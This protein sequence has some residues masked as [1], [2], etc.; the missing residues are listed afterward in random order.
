MILFV[1][2][3][4]LYYFYRCTL[5]D[6]VKVIVAGKQ[7]KWNSSRAVSLKWP[8]RMRTGVRRSFSF[9]LGRKS[10]ITV[11]WMAGLSGESTPS[12]YLKESGRPSARRHQKRRRRKPGNNSHMISIVVRHGH[13]MSIICVTGASTIIKQQKPTA[14]PGH[15]RNITGP[16][17]WLFL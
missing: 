11:F 4:S 9:F 1:F 14:Q 16:S 6:D 5:F 17:K 2:L 7:K 8:R 10:E 15:N 13:E 3:P 12:T